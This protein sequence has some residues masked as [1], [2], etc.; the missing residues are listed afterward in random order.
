MVEEL[1]LS[2]KNGPSPFG[3]LQ[4]DIGATAANLLWCNGKLTGI[5]QGDLP[6]LPLSQV[7]GFAA[8][9]SVGGI[10]EHGLQFTDVSLQLRIDTGSLS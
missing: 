8:E 4:S 1:D 5:G 10:I 2:L 9:Q 6:R 7:E 3:H